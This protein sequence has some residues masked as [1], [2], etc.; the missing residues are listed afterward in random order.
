MELCRVYTCIFF[1][2]IINRLPISCSII[3]KLPSMT[4]KIHLKYGTWLSFLN[5]SLF[6]RDSGL[7]TEHQAYYLLFY[8]QNF[9]CE[10]FLFFY[11]VSFALHPFLS[12]LKF[13][14]WA[15]SEVNLRQPYLVPT[16]IFKYSLNC[17]FQSTL[18]RTWQYTFSPQYIFVFHYL[19]IHCSY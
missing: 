18:T 11:S 8:L 9:S 14:F 5:P 17:L 19:H 4:F 2:N 10:P 3:T 6:S 1:S 12:L 7:F 13:L 16:C 15:N